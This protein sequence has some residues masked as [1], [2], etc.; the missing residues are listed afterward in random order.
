MKI[1]II[2]HGDPNYAIDSLTDRGRVEA[3]LLAEHLKGKNIDHIYISPLGR[4]Q[5]TAEYTMEALGITG[6]TLDWL[7]EFPAAVRIWE[8]AE[9]EKAM[10]V[11]W[12]DGKGQPRI[13][14]DILPSWWTKQEE[15]YDKDAWRE[16]K[17]CRHSQTAE[18]YAEVAAGLDA[19]LAKHG[20]VRDGMT[21]RVERSNSDTIAFFCHFGVECVMLS[22]L[23][24]ISPFVLWHCFQAVPTAVTV[25][26][27]EERE[28]GIASFRATQ[29]GDISHLEKGNQ[30]PSFAGRY[31]ERFEDD[32]LH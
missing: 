2:R 22:H 32:T 4:A 3:A 15:L 24:G 11:P 8:D 28:Q 19:V 10:P 12:D 23:F 7:Q 1:L 31:C 16:N 21:Y 6:Q 18:K 17:I 14:W 30:E 20:Y 9:L 26:N 27:S 29:L 5:R 25:I 13:S